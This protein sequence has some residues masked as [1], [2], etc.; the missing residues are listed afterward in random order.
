MHFRSL[1][2]ALLH[3]EISSYSYVLA[4]PL[5]YRNIRQVPLCKPAAVGVVNALPRDRKNALVG[6]QKLLDGAI[7]GRM[8]PV[9]CIALEMVTKEGCDASLDVVRMKVTTAGGTRTYSLGCYLSIATP[10]WY[11]RRMWICVQQE[12][13]VPGA[14]IERRLAGSQ[15]VTCADV[16]GQ[17]GRNHTSSQSAS[18]VTARTPVLWYYSTAAT[19]LAPC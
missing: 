5:L 4:A 11:Q 13:V 17:P 3:A 10:A 9:G 19:C 8:S 2:S 16:V 7:G 6:E 14:A 12:D 18:M 1:K 15:S